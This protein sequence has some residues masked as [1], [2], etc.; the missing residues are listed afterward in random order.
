MT[1]NQHPSAT[2]TEVLWRRLYLSRAKLKAVSRTSALLSG[3]AMVAIVEIQV[4]TPKTTTPG[5]SQNG[6]GSGGSGDGSDSDNVPD[7]LLVVFGV[8][9]TLLVTVHL[10]ALMISTCILPSMEAVTSEVSHQAVSESPHEKMR[11]CVE[12]AWICSTGV[13]ILLFMVEI[14]LLAWV[15]FNAVSP[16]AAVASTAVVVPA[17]L[18]FVVF[19]LL[20]YRRLLAHKHERHEEGLRALQAMATDISRRSRT[21]GSLRVQLVGKWTFN[22]R[23]L[24]QRSAVRI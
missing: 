20:F 5:K 22:E 3:F 21:Q 2:H 1:T 17:A 15:K 18:L 8:C 24:H 12:M 13:G 23:D 11:H 16:N 7:A 9:T 10:I 6:G 14:A 4:D 19:S